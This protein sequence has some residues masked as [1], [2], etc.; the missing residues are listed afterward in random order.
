MYFH[1]YKSEADAILLREQQEEDGSAS[2]KNT[3]ETEDSFNLSFDIH[4][5]QSEE[6][7]DE[8]QGKMSQHIS[9]SI[10]MGLGTLC[11]CV[12]HKTEKVSLRFV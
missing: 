6:S 5:E 4:E 10:R 7:F 3:K 12:F 8:S 1:K 9:I 11:M 2:N